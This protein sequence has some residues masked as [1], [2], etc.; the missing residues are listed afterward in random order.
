M[1]DVI[2]ILDEV[3][4]AKGS[5]AKIAILSQ[6]EGNDALRLVLR[7]AYDKVG[8]KWN[9][10]LKQVLA[11]PSS[12]LEGMDLLSAIA[13]MTNSL[14]AT[15]KGQNA[16]SAM[17]SLI[18]SVSEAEAEVLKGIIGR[19]LH[20]GLNTKSLNKAMPGLIHQIEYMRCDIFGA[21]HKVKYPALLQVKM[22][23]TWR[24]L[25]IQDGQVTMWTRQGHEYQNPVLS[26]IFAGCPDGRYIGE[27]TI[28]GLIRVAANGNI[29]SDDPSYDKIQF[30]LWDYVTDPKE[31][32]HNRFE[33]LKNVVPQH[34]LVK[35]VETV[36]VRSD[37]EAL[38]QAKIWM[39]RGEEGAVLKDFNA[40]FKNGTSQLQ[41]K[42]K[43]VIELDVRVTGF[44]D[45]AIGTS[46]EGKVGAIEFK[47]D[48]GA[49]EGQTSGFDQATLDAITKNP[50]QYIGKI[51]TVQCND[52]QKAEG[53]EVYRLMHPRFIEFR[54]D[55]TSTDD[56]AR[57][58]Q[59]LKLACITDSRG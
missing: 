39:Q 29:N 2:A 28:A 24:E 23:G 1:N 7:M 50:H 53:S 42:I 31:P 32:Y 6:H 38:T 27:L 59:M 25:Q 21:G 11:A 22:D 26:E 16:V 57:V 20:L 14:G 13:W 33:Q 36:I 45:G 10:A 49:I 55:K 51:M 30:T 17:H 5:K 46:R 15:I 52:L 4:A 37:E 18:D 43:H 47:T 3:K 48:D 56:L 44:T 8:F 41:L 19:D 35:I 12:K 54:D 58:Q 40:P 34:P 9:M